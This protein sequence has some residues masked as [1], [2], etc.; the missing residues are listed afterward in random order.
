[1]QIAL[2][3]A[4][5]WSLGWATLTVGHLNILSVTF[6]P[7]LIGLADNLGIHLAARYSEERAAGRDFV[8]PWRSPHGRRVR[9]LCCWGLVA[10]AFYAVMLPDLPNS[11]LL[12]GS[13]ELLCM[14]ASFTV[15]P[16]LFAVSQRYLRTRA[17][18][19]RAAA[20][21]LELAG[22]FSPSYTGG[23]WCAHPHRSRRLPKFDYNLLHLQ[24]K[25]TESVWKIAS[26]RNR[27][28]RH[29]MRS[30]RLILSQNCSAKK[31]GLQPCR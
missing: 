27:T 20:P 10:L 11:D 7:I 8:P 21:E 5:C 9:A 2:Q 15:L 17:A 25:G 14:V 26:W 4:I 13:G 29:G 30:A 1:M 28:V 24:A 6:A 16:A 12:P 3:L 23:S 31:P 18:A 22:T 19:W